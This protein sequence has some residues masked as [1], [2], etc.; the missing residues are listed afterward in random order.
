M[1]TI[2][3][4]GV[5]EGLAQHLPGHGFR[6]GVHKTTAKIGWMIPGRL[7]NAYFKTERAKKHLD[8]L[9]NFLNHYWE[10]FPAPSVSLENGR[11]MWRIEVEEPHVSLFLVAGDFFSCLRASLDHAVWRLASLHVTKPEDN[12]QFP[13]ISENDKKSAERFKK[14]TKGLPAEVLKVIESLQPYNRPTGSSLT[15]HPLWCLSKMNNIDKHRRI[16]VHPVVVMTETGILL[17]PVAESDDKRVFEFSLDRGSDPGGE[18]TT[19]IIF[20]GQEDGIMMRP[21]DLDQL[22]DYVVW[23]VLPMLANFDP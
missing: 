11:A 21:G 10:S 13:I 17:A 16:T 12:T 2:L 3:D 9:K 14:Q 1:K 22:Y 18:V 4:E 8:E 6:S 20:G 5:L 23:H 15:S 19:S 7:I